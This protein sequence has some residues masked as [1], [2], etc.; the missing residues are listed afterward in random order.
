MRNVFEALLSFTPNQALLALDPDGAL[1]ASSPAA[2]RLIGDTGLPAPFSRAL[3]KRIDAAREGVVP[4]WRARLDGSDHLCRLW[5][6]PGL[7][8]GR[9]GFL[10]AIVAARATTDDLAPRPRPPGMVDAR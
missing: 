10:V 8:G 1:L 9:R 2:S 3:M 6:V 4:P 7:D 5:A